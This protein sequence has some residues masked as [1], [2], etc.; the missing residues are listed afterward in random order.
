MRW[1][2]GKDRAQRAPGVRWNSLLL[3]LPGH[4]LKTVGAIAQRSAARNL[5]PARRPPQLEGDQCRNL[6][7]NLSQ[8]PRV[9]YVF[10]N[11][12]AALLNVRHG[13][14]SVPRLV[15]DVPSPRAHDYDDN[16]Q[17]CDQVK[18]VRHVQPRRARENLDVVNRAHHDVERNL[19]IERVGVGQH[20]DAGYANTRADGNRLHRR[21]R[22][23][24]HRAG[25]AQDR[26]EQ[27]S[28]AL[29]YVLILRGLAHLRDHLP[30][31]RHQVEDMARP[32]VAAH[33]QILP[34][35]EH[36]SHVRRDPIVAHFAL[37]QGQKTVPHI[38][39][40]HGIGKIANAHLG[41][42][43]Q[44]HANALLPVLEHH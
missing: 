29:E 20:A 33:R 14:G 17:H 10:Q 31:D 2:R 39:I 44:E 40:P 32:V 37:H 1:Q 36:R 25:M 11:P 12:A 22:N 24:A 28:I 23:R 8:R 34:M 38:R 30:L 7:Q 42:A 9:V 35:G 26:R 21:Y 13:R 27:V 16:Q 43:A 15:L 19:A 6:L 41:R 3:H 4:A 18:Q 5:A